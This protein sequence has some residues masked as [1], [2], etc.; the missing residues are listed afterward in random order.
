MIALEPI[1]YGNARRVVERLGLVPLLTQLLA[2]IKKCQIFIM[3]EK[4]GN[5]AGAIADKL[6]RMLKGVEGW[7]EGKTAEGEPDFLAASI[8]KERGSASESK[9][10]FQQGPSRYTKMWS[11][12]VVLFE[13]GRLTPVLSS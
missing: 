1:E 4:E 13:K 6:V 12:F 5:G 2:T 7:R 8:T 3:R 11:T 9:F 10:K